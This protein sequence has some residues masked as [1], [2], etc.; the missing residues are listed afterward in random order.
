[1]EKAQ[2]KLIRLLVEEP[3]IPLA[4]LH[5]IQSPTLVIGG[6]HDVIKEEHTMAIFKNIPQSYLWIIPNSGHSTPIFHKDE[7]N[8]TVD[9]FFASSYHKI[10]KEGRFR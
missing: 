1:M 8:K 4:D 10:E 5:K 7:F 2:W 3:H 9:V 6:D